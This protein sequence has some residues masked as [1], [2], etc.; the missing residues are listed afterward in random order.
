MQW[1][2]CPSAPSAFLTVSCAGRE[3]ARDE[4]LGEHQGE[5]HRDATAKPEALSW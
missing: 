4:I 3:A 1:G 5:Q 2:W